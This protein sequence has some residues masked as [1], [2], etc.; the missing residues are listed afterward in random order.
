MTTV[1]LAGT[2]RR[3]PHID[4]LLHLATDRL[5]PLE[6]VSVRRRRLASRHCMPGARPGPAWSRP[7]QASCRSQSISVGPQVRRNSTSVRSCSLRRVI[8]HRRPRS[9]HARPRIH[10]A[11]LLVWRD[12]LPTI[13]RV[14]V[15]SEAQSS[16]SA[17][18]MTGQQLTSLCVSLTLARRPLITT[19]LTF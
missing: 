9:H 5:L 11:F 1:Y 16:L 3:A 6:S 18:P 2:G 7:D 8:D 19:Y 14:I 15:A 17:A 4:D 13:N 12:N 10:R